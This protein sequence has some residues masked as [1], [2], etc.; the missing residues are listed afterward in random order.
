MAKWSIPS[1]E[2][3]GLGFGRQNF[4]TDQFEVIVRTIL[5]Q[6]VTNGILNVDSNAS[7][8]GRPILT[9][10]LK[11]IYSCELCGIASIQF[12]LINDDYVYIMVPK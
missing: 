9:L 4:S 6:L 5:S 11:T 2:K 10:M 1:Y 8:I 12:S 7:S 3:I